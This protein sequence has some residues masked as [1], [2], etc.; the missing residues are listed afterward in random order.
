MAKKDV[1]V[2]DS[3]FE[4]SQEDK[5]K[6]KRSIAT[7]KTTSKKSTNK[8]KKQN[9]KK[10]KKKKVTSK[11]KDS[12]K[13]K[14]KEDPLKKYYLPGQKYPTPE[15]VPIFHN[16]KNFGL[17]I[18]YESWYKQEPGIKTA[19]KYLLDHGLLPVELAKKLAK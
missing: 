7:K 16:P 2:S 3:E 19:E 14:S 11:T 9:S 1:Q 15:E 18:F 6:L 4:Q 17:R 13:T 5:V 12:K 10:D 8:S